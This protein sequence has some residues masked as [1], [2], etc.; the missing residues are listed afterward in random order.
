M[1]ELTRAEPTTKPTTVPSMDEPNMEPDDGPWRCGPRVRS[2]NPGFMY[3]A[4][5]AARAIACGSV[6]RGCSCGGSPAESSASTSWRCGSV[7]FENASA[8]TRSI[9]SGGAV[10]RR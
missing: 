8:C 9:V 7:S 10:R 3:S 6:D 1:N 5:V 4:R 2:M